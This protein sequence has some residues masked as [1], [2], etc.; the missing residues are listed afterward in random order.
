MIITT[1]L[2]L[3]LLEYSDIAFMLMIIFMYN[4]CI[5]TCVARI[6]FLIKMSDSI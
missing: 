6:S 2:L 5:I 1:T 3:P 4:N